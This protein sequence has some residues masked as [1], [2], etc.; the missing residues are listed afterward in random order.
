MDSISFCLKFWIMKQ[1]CN[2]DLS[3]L[4]LWNDPEYSSNK[5]MHMSKVLYTASQLRFLETT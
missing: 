5:H 2:K 4:T 1:L 3:F